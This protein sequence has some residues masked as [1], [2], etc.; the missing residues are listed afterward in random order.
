[1]SHY[2]P[3]TAT[4][5]PPLAAFLPSHSRSSSTQ[6]VGGLEAESR[7]SSRG[8]L[9]ELSQSR[10]R[11]TSSAPSCGSTGGMKQKMLL[12]YNVY[13]AKFV[14]PQPPQRSPTATDSPGHSPESSP[15]TTKKVGNRG[16]KEVDSQSG[17][18][19]VFG[20]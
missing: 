5:T 17:K 4:P 3:L 9:E 6:S 7:S 15:K 10:H 11:E 13:M 14:N 8:S 2:P 12:D 18:V 19:W 20:E 16:T 1:M